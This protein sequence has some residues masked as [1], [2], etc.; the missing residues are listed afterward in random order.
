MV[1]A[2]S[3]ED[4]IFVSGGTEANN[5][6]FHS[7]LK[8]YQK[9]KSYAQSDKMIMEPLP[10]IIVSEIEHDSVKLIAENYEKDKL[11]GMVFLCIKIVINNNVI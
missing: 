4:I 8:F 6:V 2:N 11:A 7:V 3:H 9:L 10:H 5:L 1:N